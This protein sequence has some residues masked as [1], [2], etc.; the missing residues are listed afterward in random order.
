MPSPPRLNPQITALEDLKTGLMDD[1]RR[2]TTYFPDN[3]DTTK[4]LAVALITTV[5]ASSKRDS[6]CAY[7]PV[8]FPMENISFIIDTIPVFCV[9][10]L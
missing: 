6:H 3:E 7:Q 8:N 4:E 1:H 2:D 9:D 5:T 10:F